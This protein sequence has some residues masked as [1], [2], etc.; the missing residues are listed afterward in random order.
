MKYGII[1]YGNATNIGDDIQSYAASRL[2]P[3]VDYYIEREQID[4]FRPEEDEPVIA[5]VNGW[6]SHNKLAWPPSPC[7]HLLF[8]SMHFQISDPLFI[9]ERFLEGIGGDSLRE[10]SPVGC[11]DTETLQLLERHGIG[12]YFSACAT[13]TLEPVFPKSDGDPYVLLID[14]SSAAEEYARRT[15]PHLRFVSITQ[16]DI[17]I[18]SR[19]RNSCSQIYTYCIFHEYVELV[20]T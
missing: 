13:L 3:R 8:I 14:V 12:A 7:I 4:T 9:G 20:D 5:I 19:V 1:V 11:R 6:F 17:C 2:L 10:F 15:W 18:T 16:N